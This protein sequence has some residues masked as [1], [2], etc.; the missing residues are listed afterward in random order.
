[1]H[2]NSCVSGRIL[3]YFSRGLRKLHLCGLLVS[4]F[5]CTFY[6]GGAVPEVV[7]PLSSSALG[8]MGG[9]LERA[10][11]YPRFWGGFAESTLIT[12]G[13]RLEEKSVFLQHCGFTG[14]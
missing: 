7:F 13:V 6:S 5:V 8:R 10:V 4:L 11:V 3:I 12:Q 2:M 14:T 9:L 1:M